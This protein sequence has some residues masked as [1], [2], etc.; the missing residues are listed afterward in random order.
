MPKW[1]RHITLAIIFALFLIVLSGC[2]SQPDSTEKIMET[3]RKTLRNE[4]MFCEVWQNDHFF[5]GDIQEDWYALDGYFSRVYADAI[6]VGVNYE[7]E[8][9]VMNMDS[10]PVPEVILSSNS[11]SIMLILRYE[12]GIVYSSFFSDRQMYPLKTD[13]TF[14]WADGAFHYGY[15]RLE[16]L[17]KTYEMVRIA[18]YDESN[19]PYPPKA[20]IDG[21]RVSEVEFFAFRDAQNAKEDVVWY[22]LTDDNIEQFVR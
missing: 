13:G 15:G 1:N 2:T 10:D 8:F 21:V 14:E 3:Y 5:D 16:F 20:Y 9:T 11:N 17:G 22:D 4:A 6:A 18:E 19:Y 7:L 12:K